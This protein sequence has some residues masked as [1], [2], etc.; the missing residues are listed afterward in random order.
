MANSIFIG[1]FGAS[2]NGSSVTFSTPVLFPDG[3]SALPA[4]AFVSEPSLGFFRNGAAQI[5]AQG[6]LIVSALMNAQNITSNTNI[7][8]STAGGFSWNGATKSFI[9][10]PAD[11]QMNF[12]NAGITAGI[13]IDVLT[14]AVMKV[15]TRAQ[16]GYA[17]VDCLGL[18]A[19]G[20]AGANFGP[21]A[22][23]S[24][25]IVNGIVTAAS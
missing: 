10:S 13:G 17:T 6:N 20:V 1:P 7:S 24:L 8:T 3:T 18:K 25:T 4:M 21:A 22:A 9:T 2:F 5:T 23:T 12:N 19:S 11:G 15:R 14:D 16:T